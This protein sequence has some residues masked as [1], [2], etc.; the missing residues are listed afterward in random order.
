MEPRA[1]Y[2]R[3]FNPV[4]DE[5]FQYVN[6]E[7]SDHTTGNPIT[8]DWQLTDLASG[9][10]H[11]GT[12]DP[13]DVKSFGSRNN[14]FYEPYG[15]RFQGTRGHCYEFLMRSAPAS[16]N[17][18]S[19]NFGEQVH[20]LQRILNIDAGATSTS[21]PHQI[22]ITIATLYERNSDSEGVPSSTRF[23]KKFSRYL[24]SNFFRKVRQFFTFLILE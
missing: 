24:A 20:E 17:P 16:A 12:T 14:L 21:T 7:H 22:C 1:I 5:A 23:C 19:I 10:V 11:T 18:W 3:Y 8:I 9:Q 15:L 13:L 2:F 6:Q 4:E